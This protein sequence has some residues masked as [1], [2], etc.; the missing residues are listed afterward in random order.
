MTNNEATMRAIFG[1]IILGIVAVFACVVGAC[2]GV[3]IPFGKQIELL[4]ELREV[5]T[6]IFGIVGAWA[7]IVYPAELKQKL[8]PT[9][10]TTLDPDQLANFRSLMRCL[11]FSALI[12]VA[13]LLVQYL[14]VALRQTQLV[15]Q[16]SGSL[17]RL[18]FATTCLLGVA[19]LW[20]IMLMLIPIDSADADVRLAQETQELLETGPQGRQGKRSK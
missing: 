12:V 16:S 2:V 17:R 8:R 6:I 20:V 15:Q 13:V 14:G 10:V 11:I 19:Q 4:R 3:D 7:A 9:E 18:S 5:S 1:Y